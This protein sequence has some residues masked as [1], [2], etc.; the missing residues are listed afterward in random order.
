MSMALLMIFAPGVAAAA[1]FVVSTMME[2]WRKEA[3]F[4]LRIATLK[5]SWRP[6]QCYDFDSSQWTGRLT[7]PTT[8]K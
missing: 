1:V 4:N 2:D 6:P 7:N 3:K 8:G 5:R